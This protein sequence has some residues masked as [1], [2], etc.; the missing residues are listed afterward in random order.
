MRPTCA[1]AY[2]RVRLPMPT[3]HIISLKKAYLPET[4]GRK[5]WVRCQSIGGPTTAAVSWSW[6]RPL[7]GVASVG[8]RAKGAA[9]PVR[10]A[11]GDGAKSLI[12]P[13]SKVI[14]IWAI[15]AHA[16]TLLRA[17]DSL[18]AARSEKGLR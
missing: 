8:G 15:G 13:L 18:Y 16:A 7:S 2:G 6:L 11:E 3:K 9:R 17:H 14:S 1:V 10:R 4:S 5:R 12:A